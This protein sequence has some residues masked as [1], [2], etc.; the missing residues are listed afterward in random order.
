MQFTANVGKWGVFEASVPGR[1][2]GNP[3]VDYDIRGTFEGPAERVEVAGFYDGDGT[4]RVRFMPSFEGTYTF[5]IE[6]SYALPD[7]QPAEGSFLVGPPEE[8]NH[9]P[10]RVANQFHFAY[11]DGTPYYSIGTTCY[12]WD[13]QDDARIEQTFESLAA[14][15]FNKI[16]FCVWPKH[17][18][19]NLGEPRSYPYVGTP[20][21]SSVLTR[22]NFSQ[23]TVRR[24]FHGD[25]GNHWDFYRFNPEHFRHIEGLIQRLGDMGIEADLIVM[26]PYDRWGFSCMEPDQDDL[27]WRYVIARF[28]AYRNVWWALA[29]EYD[30]FE[31]KTIKDWERY[32]QILVNEDPYHHLRSIHN[33][34]PFYDHTRPWI[35]H[36][37][38]QRQDLYKGA[39]YT[40]EWRVR[41]NKPVVLD[42]ICYE[43]NIQHGWGNISGREMT[44]RFWECAVRGGYPGHGETYLSDD[45]ILWWSHGG[46]LRG[47]SWKRFQL[48]LDVLSECPG[49][50]LKPWEGKRW[51]EIAAVPQL[52]SRHYPYSY[53]LLYFGLQQTSFRDFKLDPAVKY[54]VRVIDTWNMTVE[55]RG[56]HSGSFRVELPGREYMALL[57]T[58]VDD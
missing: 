28:A 22:E 4:Y 13:L 51:D 8:G 37:S 14:S 52:E 32:A 46:P 55:D 56:I 9:G 20:M 53:Y 6:G 15:A 58:K 38:I 30:L 36:C 1:T 24:D 35:T 10:M 11:E 31:C 39:E 49:Y 23:Y 40:D 41:Y 12:V 16:R 47:E 48:L 26:H 7:A 21:D 34:K 5:R 50:G 25:P 42:E 2:E 33:C 44:R 43:G 18:D 27:Y 54:R 29:N 57:L 3:F 19:Y 45:D 17:Y